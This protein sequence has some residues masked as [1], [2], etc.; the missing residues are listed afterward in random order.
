M[1][2]EINIKNKSQQLKVTPLSDDKHCLY[3]FIQGPDF[4]LLVGREPDR[5][6]SVATDKSLDPSLLN[7]ILRKLE[8]AS[9][10]MW[11]D[12]LH[13]INIPQ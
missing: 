6:W 9:I 5:S 3:F 8:R 12:D 10:Y 7:R 4:S 2:L 13:M 11:F 1:V